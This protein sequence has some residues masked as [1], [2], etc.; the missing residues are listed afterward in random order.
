MGSAGSEVTGAAA[1][2]G[3]VNTAGPPCVPRLF[4]YPQRAAF[5]RSQQGWLRGVL[6]WRLLK[7]YCRLSFKSDCISVFEV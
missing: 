4:E 2:S 3:R 6:V 7:N 5:H 1:D